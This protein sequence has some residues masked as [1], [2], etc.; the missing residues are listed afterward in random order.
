MI[1]LKVLAALLTLFTAR[2]VVLEYKKYTTRKL[3]LADGFCDLLSFIKGELSCR[4]RPVAEW[5][6]EFHNAALSESGFLDELLKRGSLIDAFR[7]PSHSCL[8]EEMTRL[9]SGYFSSFGKTYKDEEEG[10][11][12]RVFDELMRLSARERADSQRS[13]K[14]VRVITYAVALGVIILII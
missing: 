14:T 2:T 5:A 10:E 12:C 9:L 7:L 4:L 8:G 1:V 6:K 11:A 13:L 3:L